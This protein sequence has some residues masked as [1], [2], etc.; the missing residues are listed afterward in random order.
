[1]PS[2]KPTGVVK[3]L[4]NQVKAFKEEIQGLKEALADAGYFIRKLEKELIDSKEAT[5]TM[6]E[7][8]GIDPKTPIK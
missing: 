1:M 8:R 7:A 4:R 3:D 6:F 5:Q 2:K